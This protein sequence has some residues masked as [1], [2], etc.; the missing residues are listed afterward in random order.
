MKRIYPLLLSL[1]FIAPVFGSEHPDPFKPLDK[2]EW[3]LESIKEKPFLLEVAYGDKERS[4]SDEPYE[5]KIEVDPDILDS[6]TILSIAV[7]PN[8]SKRRDGILSNIEFQR[9]RMGASI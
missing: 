8:E 7:S 1:F 6:S 4:P 9:I 5:T 3:Q 2:V